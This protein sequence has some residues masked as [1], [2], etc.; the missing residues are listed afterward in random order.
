MTEM[1]SLPI[2]E[3]LRNVKELN[4]MDTESV[5]DAA[6]DL[7]AELG[8]CK[9]REIVLTGQQFT[10]HMA[11]GMLWEVVDKVRQLRESKG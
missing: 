1:E 7:A 5:Y 10:L 4:F 6:L 9:P 8:K 3:D 2:R 11:Y